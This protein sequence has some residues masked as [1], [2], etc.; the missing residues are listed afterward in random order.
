MPGGVLDCAH[1]RDPVGP[2]GRTLVRFGN[3]RFAAAIRVAVLADPDFVA[4]RYARFAFQDGVGAIL[5]SATG[6]SMAP[7]S[8][9][10]LPDHL[11]ETGTCRI[12]RAAGS[13]SD[14]L[15]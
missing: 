15:P 14:P 5:A 3:R 10:L 2:A 13:A 8:A 4:V 11:V 1:R 6:K 9:K 7:F 12:F